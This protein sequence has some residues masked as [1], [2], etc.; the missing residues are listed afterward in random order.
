MKILLLSLGLFALLFIAAPAV[1]AQAPGSVATYGGATSSKTIDAG[2]TSADISET[3]YIGPGT[4]KI[5]GTWEIYASQIVIDPSAVITGAGTIKFFNPSDAGGAASSTQ[6]DANALVNAIDV[7]MELNN[8]SGM[9]LTE[10]V[11][12]VELTGDG[13][14]DNTASADLYVGKDLNLN[15]DGANITLGTVVTGDLRFDNDATISNYRP[16]RMVVVNNSILSH[17][18]KENF[19][20]AF[21]FPIGIAAGDYTP[22]QVTNTGSQT[23]H[24]SVQDY[25]ASA[26]TEG[27]T[28]GIDRTWNLY[29]DN[30]S[31]NSLID[32]QHNNST[33]QTDFNL[34]ANF[35]TQNSGTAPNI[36]GQAGTSLT[37]W[38]SNNFGIATTP[39][40]LTT[41]APITDAS[42]RSLIYTSFATTATDMVAYFSQS[43]NSFE[44]LPL[45]LTGFTAAAVQCSA[46]L[47]WTTANEQNFNH[48]DVQSSTD[49]IGFNKIGSIAS[50]KNPLGSSYTFSYAAPKGKFIYRLL[51]VD[52]DGHYSYSN[53]VVASVNCD[54]ARVV[55]VYPNPVVNQLT[56]KGDA[57]ELKGMR[58]Y[59]MAGQDVSNIIKTIQ[60]N[61]ISMVLDVSKLP[62][63]TYT[64]KTK[65]SITKISKQ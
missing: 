41:G 53:D 64:V 4:H 50:H 32:F 40:T 19:T 28:N 31:G 60:N 63:G 51:M 34:S 38:Q 54:A 44:T 20:S 16:E 27:G 62:A 48:F 25:A 61:S 18:V 47:N 2:G 24:L 30:A 56:V 6:I 29:A 35:I 8:A 12:P 46:I 22:A 52:N 37:A 7:N 39:G 42:E 13:W 36:S 3:L 1:H 65:T 14:S 5:D 45:T 17:V 23:I 11:F 10:T 59:N 57:G 43:S 58:M 9:V 55:V 15:V 49:G 21:T 26:S 33:N